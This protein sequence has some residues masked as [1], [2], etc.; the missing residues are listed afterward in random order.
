MKEFTG[1]ELFEAIKKDDVPWYKGNFFDVVDMSNPG[2]VIV[3]GACALGVAAIN[4]GTYPEFNLSEYESTLNIQFHN[5][6]TAIV[7][8]ND[9]SFSSWKEVVEK[10]EEVLTPFFDIKLRSESREYVVKK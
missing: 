9:R 5:A 4:L 6:L 7:A 2:R 1:R 3:G 10:A 8:A